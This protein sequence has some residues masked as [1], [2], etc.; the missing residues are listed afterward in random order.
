MGRFP[1][2]LSDFIEQYRNV[3]QSVPSAFFSVSLTAVHKNAKNKN[4]VHEIMQ[5]FFD[6]NHW[7]PCR[8]AS[9]AGALLYTHYGPVIRFIARSISKSAGRDTNIHRDYTYTD[10]NEIPV[11]AERIDS[12]IKLAAQE[13]QLSTE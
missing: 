5:E 4:P 11:F 2:V 8:K 7:Q 6:K 13:R 12:M 1:G 10:W 3:L 9:F